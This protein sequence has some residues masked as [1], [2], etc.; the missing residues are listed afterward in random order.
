MIDSTMVLSSDPE[1]L[2]GARV[3]LGTRVPVRNLLDYL[4]AGQTLDMFLE[5]FPS[6]SREQAQSA[7]E[8]AR[9]ALTAG[10]GSS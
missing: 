6:V 2:G 8:M 5:D 3:F 9:E 4:A 1:I 10:A 7:L